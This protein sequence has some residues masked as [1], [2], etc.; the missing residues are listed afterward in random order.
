MNC[1]SGLLALDDYGSGYNSEKNLLEIA[2]EFIKV[3]MSIIRD[4]DSNEDKQL[5]VQNLV[6]YA[7]KREMLVLAEGI[8][9]LAE[10]HKVLE[11]GVDLLQGY[12]LARPNAVPAPIAES[13]K[14]MI[15]N[16]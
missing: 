1:Y 10:L 13:A 16:F 14:E 9:T 5:I 7:H 3:D 2:P 4:I 15:V 8:E 12:A 11:L 6:Q